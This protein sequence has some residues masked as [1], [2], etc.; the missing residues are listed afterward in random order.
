LETQTNPCKKKFNFFLLKINFLSFWCTDFKNNFLKIKKYYFNVFQHEKH[1]KKQP[2]PHLILL[3]Q[4]M[5]GSLRYIFLFCEICTAAGEEEE[6]RGKKNRNRRVSGLMRELC[7][8]Y[9]WE[10]GIVIMEDFCF[11]RWMDIFVL[12]WWALRR[13]F[14][15]ARIGFFFFGVFF[16][17]YFTKNPII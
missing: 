8:W 12:F 16:W 15:L 17:I 11:C 2:Q 13:F 6:K 1:F 7:K 4:L 14:F 10:L 5:L 9:N 3:F